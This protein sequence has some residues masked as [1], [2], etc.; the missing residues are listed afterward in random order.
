MRVPL[1]KVSNPTK[2]TAGWIGRWLP[3]LPVVLVLAAASA[4]AASLP[5]DSLPADSAPA[6]SNG[7]AAAGAASFRKLCQSC[8][9]PVAGKNGIGPSLHGVYGRPAGEAPGFR[10]SDAMRALGVTWTRDTLDPYLAS[11]RQFL[12][13]QRMVFVGIRDPGERANVI[14]YLEEL[15]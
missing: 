14:R 8:H 2:R 6:D 3:W 7:D 1:V 5:A 4:H 9:S 15:K 12:S 11:P 10:Y 13:G